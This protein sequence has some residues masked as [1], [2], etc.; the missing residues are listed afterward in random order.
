M[1]VEDLMVYKK[2]LENRMVGLRWSFSENKN[3]I[4]FI[5]SFDGDA[6]TT[7]S[8]NVTVIPPIKCSTWPDYYCH[9]FNN[10]SVSGNYTFKV[11]I[12]KQ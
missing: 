9:T 11:S 12:E 7:T 2:S 4:G 8:Q 10:L 3:L 1:P 6:P 5:V